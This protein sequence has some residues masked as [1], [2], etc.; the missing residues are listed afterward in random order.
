MGKQRRKPG[1]VLVLDADR[2]YAGYVGP[3]EARLLLKKRRASIARRSPLVLLLPR[4]ARQEIDVMTEPTAIAP[5]PPARERTFRNS[6][7]A[8][9]GVK[10]EVWIQNISEYWISL[11]IETKGDEPAI[12]CPIPL[13]RE[14]ICLTE[15]ASFEALAASSNF[16]KLLVRQPRVL[17]R[18]TEAQAYE[19]YEAAASAWG[20]GSAEEA[21]NA[22]RRVLSDLRAKRP[23]A[24]EGMAVPEGLMFAPPKSQQELMGLA[25]GQ[26]H[27]GQLQTGGRTGT[28]PANVQDSLKQQARAAGFAI[29]QAIT[30][31]EE[32]NPAVLETCL[33]LGKNVP[34][35][36]RMPAEQAIRKF[37]LL[38][39]RLKDTDFAYIETRGG[40]AAVKAWARNKAAALDSD[41]V[42]EVEPPAY[43]EGVIGP[44]TAAPAPAGP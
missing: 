25:A 39:P 34:P 41:D 26:Q 8:T 1:D 23:I 36:E 33:K 12:P 11:E 10:G 14:P 40:Y 31:D 29:G 13:M 4:I 22:A 44:S 18:L 37:E 17:V 2:R 42:I 5:A 20:L 19:W 6:W 43:G 27:P 28:T 16:K 38:L 7:Q 15:D 32:V 3:A 21:L 9:L 30:I 35:H 24:E